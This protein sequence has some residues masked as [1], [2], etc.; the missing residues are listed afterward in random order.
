MTKREIAALGFT[1]AGI[2]VFADTIRYFQYIMLFIVRIDKF[3]GFSSTAQGVGV[4]LMLSMSLGMSAGLILARRMLARWMFPD[5][6]GSDTPRV[7]LMAV[8]GVAFS[9]IGVF[10]AASGLSEMVEYCV[11]VMSRRTVPSFWTLLRYGDFRWVEPTLKILL[12]V[13][14]FFG[15]QQLARFWAKLRTAGVRREMG[16]CVRCGYDLTGNVS[17]VCPECG[18]QVEAPES[19]AARE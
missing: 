18:M 7:R 9:V 15:A 14:L 12:G 16:L 5:E 6:E 1:L 3:T 8:Q 10:L 11:Q 17:G 2:Y 19:E 4:V 13:G